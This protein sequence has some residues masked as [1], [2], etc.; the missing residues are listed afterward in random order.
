MPRFTQN[1]QNFYTLHGL[2][3]RSPEDIKVLEG[4]TEQSIR[5]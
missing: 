4:I 5:L 1:H 2:N 3:L